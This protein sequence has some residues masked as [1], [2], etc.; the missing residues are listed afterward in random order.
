[1]QVIRECQMR[2]VILAELAK[3]APEFED[4]LHYVA[5]E[6]LTLAF[7]IEQLNVRAD[8]APKSSA[9]H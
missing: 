6:W 3:D 1:M 8:V 4:Q 2:A 9:R 5:K 7:L